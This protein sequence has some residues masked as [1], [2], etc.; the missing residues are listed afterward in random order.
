M[1]IWRRHPGAWERR[2][3]G[4]IG[5]LLGAGLLLSVWLTAIKLRLTFDPG[6]RSSCNWSSAFDCD[7][8][9]ASRFATVLDVPIAV[10][11]FATYAFLAIW[12][13]LSL[14]SRDRDARLTVL[15]AVALAA[16]GYSAYLA[17]V[18]IFVIGAMCIYCTALYGVNVA[19]AA[20]ALQWLR[21]RGAWSRVH[22]WLDQPAKIPPLLARAAL[23][24]AA[25][26]TVTLAGFAELREEFH[27]RRIALAKAELGAQFTENGRAYF[28]APVSELDFPFGSA[29]AA[30]TVVEFGD[31]QC[32]FCAQFYRVS[33]PLRAEFGDRVRWVFK[34]F[35]ANRR[36]NPHVRGE[37][38]RDACQAAR[39]A[40]CAGEQGRFWAM[41][42]Q[43]FDSE[44]QLGADALRASAEAVGLDPDVWSACMARPGPDSRI[45]AH[46]EQGRE[47]GVVHTP[48][49][50]IGGR[51][52]AGVWTPEVLTTLLRAALERPAE[53]APELR[54][55]PRDDVMLELEAAGE[56]FWID[57]YEASLDAS[58][59]ARTRSGAIPA[60][61]NWF[62]ADRACRNAGKRLCTSEEWRVACRGDVDPPRQFPYGDFHA[63]DACNDS[64]LRP[65]GL[66][67]TGSYPKCITPVGVHDLSGNV[68]EWTGLR[69]E[70]ARLLGSG[71]VRAEG[72]GLGTCDA[73]RAGH[74]RPRTRDATSGFRCCA[75][76]P[77]ESA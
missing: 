11:G 32:P 24:A 48:T 12:L 75:A 77:P 45:A 13:L 62:A 7:A 34:H 68:E 30:V 6:Y 66:R 1:V 71:F 52:V 53:F 73:Q 41:H 10:F 28:N 20:L 31:F 2:Y 64:S 37:F 47:A 57:A 36:C 23:V 49:T 67:A 18:T 22:A 25:P 43:L 16:C 42:D 58:G 61:V 26:F 17:Y 63:P 3:A 40:N 38:H 21:R 51:L 33:K 39:A 29:D 65:G 4:A 70:Q 44:Y 74:T 35:P 5:G 60:R 69:R 8:V 14:R 9:Q 76:G 72:S 56:R 15:L 55:T 59:I 50:Y 46:V 27:E 19:A 54:P